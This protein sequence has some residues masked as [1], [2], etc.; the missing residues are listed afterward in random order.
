VA[1][2]V[3]CP[4]CGTG[5]DIDEGLLGK[6]LRCAEKRCRKAFRVT[7]DGATL[8]VI[9][10]DKRA[11]SPSADWSSSPPPPVQTGPAEGDWLSAPP[12]VSGGMGA[13]GAGYAPAPRP[14]SAAPT[15]PEEE[16]YRAEMV[17][18]EAAEEEAETT[19]EAQDGHYYATYPTRRKKGKI[20][21]IGLIVVLAAGIIIG[22]F[23]LRTKI[24]SKK[25]DEE[26]QAEAFVNNRQWT[27]GKDAFETLLKNYPQDA[28]KYRCYLSF[29]AVELDFGSEKL[30]PAEEGLAKFYQQFRNEGIYRDKDFRPKVWDASVR[31][32]ERAADL[33]DQNA[34]PE[35]RDAA[36]RMLKIARDTASG[37][38]DQAEAQRKMEAAEA[39]I[40]QATEAIATRDAGRSL[41]KLIDQV[42]QAQQPQGV[43]E[44]Q[45]AYA[46]ALAKHPRLAQ[47]AELA[48]KIE[49]LRGE[50]PGWIAFQTIGTDA[51][52][53]TTEAQQTSLLVSPPIKA[54][55]PGAAAQG[56]VLAVARGTVYGLAAKNGEPLWAIR[57]GIDQQS[58]P[59][60][61]PTRRGQ[62]D[63]ALILSMN[64]HKETVLNA[65]DVN[66]GRRI[67]HRTLSA[68][69]PAGPL[70]V[71][72]RAYVP[73]VD[74]KLSVINVADGK[75]FGA[76][77]TGA[78]LTVPLGYD[79]IGNMLYAAAD[80][81]RI[82]VFDLAKNVC[83][84]VVY[85]NHAAGLLRGAPI[86]AGQ[87]RVAGGSADAGGQSTFVVAEG[88]GMGA[89]KVRVFACQTKGGAEKPLLEF[90]LPGQSWFTPYF[91]G[92]VLGLVTDKGYLAVFGVNRQTSDPQP[93]IPIVAG[94]VPGL[95]QPGQDPGT[96]Q[97]KA[98]SQ[99]AFVGL[100]D[101]WVLAENKLLRVRLD[102]F[103]KHLVTAPALTVE[104]GAPLHESTLSPD[105]KLVVV[106]SLSPDRRILATALDRVTGAVVWQRQLGLAPTQDPVSLGDDVLTIDKSGALFLVESRQLPAAMD[107]PWLAI[108]EW[109]AG[110]V[111]G[112]TYARLQ[113]AADGKSA[114][115]LAYNSL[116]HQ[117]VLRRFEA[118]RGLVAER[119]YLMPSPPSGSAAV[120][121][122]GTVIIPCLNGNL[123]EFN[124]NQPNPVGVVGAWRYTG[125]GGTG[126]GRRP[127]A[128]ASVPGHALLLSEKELI[129]TDGARRLLRWERT[130]GKTWAQIK[131]AEMILPARITTGIVA[132]RDQSGEPHVCV[133]DETGK[134][135]LLSVGALPA[136]REWEVKGAITRGPFCLG[137]HAIGCIVDGARLAWFDVNGPDGQV[138]TYDSSAS[139]EVEAGIVGQPQAVGDYI[140]VPELAGRF[141]WLN[142]KTGEPTMAPVTLAGSLIPASSAVPLGKQWFFAPV[143]DGTVMLLPLPKSMP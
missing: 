120:D 37:E 58:L 109:P 71:G 106:V 16:M 134:L 115:A 133:G 48:D 104:L 31:I 128:A 137:Q 113:R 118:G 73:T 82:F 86:I 54:A 1:I 2:Q 88:S 53:A 67:W 28:E 81:K 93:L 15:L 125:D 124:V 94:V 83:S 131:A 72:F 11:S 25:D 32:G 142:L 70:L 132:V 35:L 140:L 84:H 52:K 59:A 121:E 46:A 126:P 100:D 39:K 135:Y 97:P 41:D 101:W 112:M 75:L 5:A 45:A 55:P 98:P 47:N 111:K 90:D 13:P 116:T 17:G 105:G 38:R 42:R 64:E 76:Y 69:C 92:D 23:V 85:T 19:Y 117:M 119:T 49:A 33:A 63:L 57:V 74:G 60:R 24:V 9:E 80:A 130:D 50:E 65:I 43:E 34:D 21:G 27:R 89:V 96:L 122:Q 129:A 18:A 29:I 139:G 68:A 40:A 87:S 95:A 20:V 110:N 108:G 61:L 99:V 123:Y 51:E 6:K 22:A 4:F 3:K 127:G 141:T 78:R 8:P 26:R 114:I 14:F 136:Q 66:N 103:R 62:Q 44:A 56:V 79:P 30:K 36:A 12:P 77:D 107:A 7:P 143:S 102:R 91:D 10:R 138:L